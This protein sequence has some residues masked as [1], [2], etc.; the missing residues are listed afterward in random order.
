MP[1][2]T[3]EDRQGRLELYH[4]E[5]PGC[6]PQS[7]LQQCIE[8]E[9]DFNDEGRIKN[10]VGCKFA[11][12][13][14]LFDIFIIDMLNDIDDREYEAYMIFEEVPIDGANEIDTIKEEE[15]TP[16]KIPS[17]GCEEGAAE[18]L[19]EIVGYIPAATAA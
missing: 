16:Q 6:R 8:S 12:S 1:R 17:P 5:L 9:D 13:T 3:D 10:G 14:D 11:N 15:E 4:Q 18:R 2:A 7:K 19:I